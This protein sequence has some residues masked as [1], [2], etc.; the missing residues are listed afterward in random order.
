MAVDPI[1]HHYAGIGNRALKLDLMSSDLEDTRNTAKMSA[2]ARSTRSRELSLRVR[3]ALQSQNYQAIV[4][5][6]Q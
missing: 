6:D 2:A 3:Q 5:R 1:I 4:S